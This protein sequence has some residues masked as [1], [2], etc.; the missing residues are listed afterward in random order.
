MAV[1]DRQLRIVRAN[2]ILRQ[3]FG[4]HVG[5]LCHEVYKRSAERCPECPALRSFNDGKVHTA[6]SAGQRQD[7][8][9]ARYVV[10]TAPLARAGE[11]VEYVIEILHDVTDVLELKAA[12]VRERQLLHSVVDQSFD[13]I[14]ATEADG[15]IAIVNP[16]AESL[17]GVTAEELRGSD[18]LERVYPAEFL[19]VLHSQG[20][21]CVLPRDQHPGRGGRDPDPFCRRG[22]ARCRQ[23]PRHR[24]L[25]PGPARAPAARAGEARRGAAG[26]RGPAP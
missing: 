20:T 18:L 17:L 13:G 8:S 5:K 24:R 9:L 4:D 7:G 10:T 26:R 22:P 21:S 16:A 3:T 25:P 1:L 14:V 15:R 11:P 19:D 2:E 6:Q 23:P 12:L